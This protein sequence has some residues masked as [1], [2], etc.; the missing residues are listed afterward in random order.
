MR[1]YLVP[2]AAGLRDNHGGVVRA[3]IGL[4]VAFWAECKGITPPKPP[5]VK[6]RGANHRKPAARCQAN[7]NDCQVSFFRAH[8]CSIL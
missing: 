7:V 8:G 5:D 6:K 4:L 2:F 3:K 1:A